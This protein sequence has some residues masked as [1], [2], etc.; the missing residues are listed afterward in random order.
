MRDMYTF[1]SSF[2]FV[3]RKKDRMAFPLLMIARVTT[4]YRII[5]WIVTFDNLGATLV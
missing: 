4:C 5:R 3:V 2:G 1:Y